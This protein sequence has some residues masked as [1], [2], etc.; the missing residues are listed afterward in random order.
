[1]DNRAIAKGMDRIRSEEE[2]R[3]KEKGGGRG[4]PPTLHSRG[5]SIQDGESARRSIAAAKIEDPADELGEMLSLGKVSSMDQ[6]QPSLRSVASRNWN[7]NG[8]E[9]A[10]IRLKSKHSKTEL[11]AVCGAAGFGKSSLVGSVQATARKHGYFTSSKFDQVRRTPF[12]PMM[13]ILSSLF[14]QIF[15]EEN[16]NSPFHDNIRQTV[17]P[18]WPMLHTYLDLP[19]WLLTPDTN[20]RASAS[21]PA[22]PKHASTPSQPSTKKTCN[23][24]ATQEWL[25]SG[26]SNK[27][28]KVFSLFIDVLRLLAMQKFICFCLDDLQFADTECIDLLQQVVHARI[29]VVIILTYRAEDLLSAK[30]KAIVELATKVELGAFTDEETAQYVSQTLLRPQEYCLPLAAV[31]Q[32]KTRG[33]PFFIREMLDSCYRKKCVYYCWRCSHWEFNLDRV[34]DAFASPDSGKFSTNDFI[35]RRMMELPNEAQALLSWGALIGDRFSYNLVKYV[36]RVAS[37][38]THHRRSFCHLFRKI[39][40]MGCRSHCR[41]SWL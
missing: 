21:T 23:G 27:T 41:I 31:I 9:S 2:Q 22:Q 15:S 5:S 10:I 25:R 13:R 40:C 20:V 12:E 36:M 39:L 32:E 1:V 19:Q 14:R 26:G 18:Y 3:R 7:G 28:S 6:R 11:I 17:Q 30:C 38:R 35:L 29:P 16:V 24:A 34:F 33:N 37:A 8:N 4:T